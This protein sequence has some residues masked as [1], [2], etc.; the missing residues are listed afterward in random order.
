MLKRYT[1][2]EM[3]KIWTESSYFS[4][5]LEVEKATARFQARLGII[6]KRS[7]EALIKKSRFDLKKIKEYEK[8]TR[9]DVTAF[10]KTVADYVGPPH[11]SW[12]HFGLT[13]SDVLDTARALQIKEAERVLKK[14]FLRAKKALYQQAKKHSGTLQVGRTHGQGA[15]P[16]SF[17]LKLTGHLLELQRHEGRVLKALKQSQAMKLSG[18]VGTYSEF[19]PPELEKKVALFLGLSV[20][21]VSTQVVARDRYAELF[22]SFALLA[23]GLERLAVE[24]RH[25]QFSEVGEVSESFAKGQTGSSAMPHKK[26]PIYSENITGLSRLI[27]SHTTAAM[28]NTVLWHER[29][30]SH[31]SVERAILPSVFIFSDFALH[32]MAEVIK[33]LSVHTDQMKKNLHSCRGTECSSL[34]LPLFIKKGMPK[35]Q[36]YSVIQQSGFLSL[37]TKTHLKQNLLKNKTLLKYLS[38]KDMDEVFSLEKKQKEI[39]L[40]VQK[41]LKSFKMDG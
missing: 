31:S 8:T 37:K 25:L 1:R 29:D 5:M 17:G 16:L 7:A 34:L 30:I 10:L 9:H 20:E 36:A 24:V 38:K 39:S 40:R 3:G 15:A 21:T 23:C 12:L 33:N 6:P 28:E 13:S 18:P 32:R 11:N 26:N 2:E 14:S 41:I 4:K 19:C 35:E 22:L 27:R